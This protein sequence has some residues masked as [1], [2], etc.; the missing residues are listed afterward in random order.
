[1]RY[2]PSTVQAGITFRLRFTLFKYPAEN[3][4]AFL[5]LRGPENIDLDAVSEDNQNKFEVSAEETKAWKG[6]QYWYCL[7]VIKDTGVQQLE[8]GTIKIKSD[9]D[10]VNGVL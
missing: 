7:R 5:I 1:M 2:I 10:Q 4:M 3:W 6:G 9:L 8:E